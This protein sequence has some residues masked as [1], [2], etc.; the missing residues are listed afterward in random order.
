MNEG[1]C[2]AVIEAGLRGQREPYLVFIVGMRRSDLDIAGQNGIGGGKSCAEQ[3]GGSDSQ[4]QDGPAEER[5]ACNRQR[6]CDA[7]ETP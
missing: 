7:D 1:K 2:S 4:A 5:Y 6:H 3:E